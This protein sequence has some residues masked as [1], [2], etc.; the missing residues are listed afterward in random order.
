MNDAKNLKTHT[1]CRSSGYG[2]SY[3]D[4]EVHLGKKV[5]DTILEVCPLVALANGLK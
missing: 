1:R 2:Y 3:L 4:I 5:R